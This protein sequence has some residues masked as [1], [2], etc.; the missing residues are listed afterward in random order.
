MIISYV[1]SLSVWCVLEHLNV[2]LNHLQ[3]IISLFTF[4]FL[5]N[6]FSYPW[7]SSLLP[8]STYL[9]SVVCHLC[10]AFWV[11]N[12]DSSSLRMCAIF[13]VNKAR[14][15]TQVLAFT[16][17][18]SIRRCSAESDRR[19]RFNMSVC[20]CNMVLSITAICITYQSQGGREKRLW[21]NTGT[22]NK[23]E[24]KWKE[25]TSH[26]LHSAHTCYD[27]CIHTPKK[28]WLKQHDSNQTW[29]RKNPSNN[30]WEAMQGSA[31][32]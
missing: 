21:D 30:Q 25:T 29:A 19:K 22:Q 11:D 16:N 32:F 2:I 24:K 8:F 4:G 5:F 17:K 27:A 28:R 20:V 1:P 9:P 7:S 10:L 18:N 23:M 13:Q 14:T 6:C 3:G 15:Q 31:M 26:L 12:P